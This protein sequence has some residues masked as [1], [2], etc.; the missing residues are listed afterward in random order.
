MKSKHGFGSI[1]MTAAGILLCLTLISSYLSAGMYA[2]FVSS[3]TAT[4]SARV[5]AFR[6]TEDGRLSTAFSVSLVPGVPCIVP[7]QVKNDS[8]VAVKYSIAIKNE[9]ENLPL[10]FTFKVGGVTTS[11]IEEDGSFVN[12]D[13]LAPSSDIDYTLEIHWEPTANPDVNDENCERIGYVDMI[14]VSLTAEQ[15]D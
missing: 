10:S 12:T 3:D 15:V 1:V 9:T 11:L 7:V 5:A 2:R 14:T 8:E 13:N 6:I 4:D